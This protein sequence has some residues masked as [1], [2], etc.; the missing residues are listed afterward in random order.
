MIAKDIPL[1]KSVWGELKIKLLVSPSQME[2]KFQ[3]LYFH[4][5]ANDILNF[6][7][8]LN[9]VHLLKCIVKLFVTEISVSSKI[10]LMGIGLTIEISVAVL[11]SDLTVSCSAAVESFSCN[12]DIC[13]RTLVSSFTG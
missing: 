13:T 3:F 12:S 4:V 9:F 8:G 6:P 7:P 2:S 1:K 10:A 11:T 5:P